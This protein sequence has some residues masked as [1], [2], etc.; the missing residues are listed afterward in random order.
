MRLPERCWELP[1]AFSTLPT[2]TFN[3][4]YAS[5][6]HPRFEY[7]KP[8]IYASTDTNIVNLERV[9]RYRT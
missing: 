2:A 6:V 7:G 8:G 4:P 9:Q 3:K 5:H 1:A